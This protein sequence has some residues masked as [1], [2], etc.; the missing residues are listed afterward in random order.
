M[1]DAGGEQWL[2]YNLGLGESMLFLCNVAELKASPHT[3]PVPCPS[4]P[5]GCRHRTRALPT[6]SRQP[7]KSTPSS[8]PNPNPI[9]LC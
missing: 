9:H 6:L 5:Q 4:S 3:Y 2:G 8:S 7:P 1:S